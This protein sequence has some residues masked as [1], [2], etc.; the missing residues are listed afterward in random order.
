MVAEKASNH[1]LGVVTED[2]FDDSLDAVVELKVHF[3]K[4]IEETEERVVLVVDLRME[5]VERC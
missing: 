3:G 1:P 5:R 4:L 2:E